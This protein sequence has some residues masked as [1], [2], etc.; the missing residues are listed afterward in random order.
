MSKLK[1]AT[2]VAAFTATEVAAAGVGVVGKQILGFYA[3]PVVVGASAMLSEWDHVHE[4]DKIREEYENE[5]SARLGKPAADLK[6]KDLEK[7][8]SQNAVISEAVKRSRW[9]RNLSMAVNAVAIVGAFAV[10]LTVAGAAAEAFALGL[11]AKAAV[12]VAASAASFLAIEGTLRPL[13]EKKLGLREPSIGKVVKNPDRQDELSLPSQIKYIEHLQSRVNQKKPETFVS[14]E[15][16]FKVFLKAN[17]EAAS[18]IRAE[19]G[20]D[21]GKLSPEQRV[22]V[23]QKAGKEIGLEQI[24]AD[25]NNGAI[26]AQEL[27]FLVQGESSGVPRKEA[28]RVTALEKEHSY[29]QQKLQQAQEQIHHLTQKVKAQST[30][31]GS[32]MHSNKP[33][34]MDKVEAATEV[35]KPGVHAQRELARRQQQ[36]TAAL[37]A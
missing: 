35:Q 30:Q 23:L 25:I 31:I 37:G 24:T 32:M 9:K 22:L 16:V 33:V 14:Q 17:P 5:I 20:N 10:A 15:Q 6:N 12:G 36:G 28:P 26:R 11:V 13:G 3:A 29:I 1:E 21:F 18:R 34:N 27:A 19:N 2:H 8:G 7:I 4:K